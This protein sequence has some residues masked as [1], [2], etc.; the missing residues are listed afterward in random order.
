[1]NE[2]LSLTSRTW[3]TEATGCNMMN[4]MKTYKIITDI[5]KKSGKE[6]Q[7]IKL[8]ISLKL[9]SAKHQEA[10]KYFKH[11]IWFEYLYLSS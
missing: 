7:T 3:S 9:K 11:T 8:G 6:K 2:V 4:N 5:T 10:Y 1:M